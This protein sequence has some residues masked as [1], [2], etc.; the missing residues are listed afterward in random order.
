ML[1]PTNR[2]TYFSLFGVDPGTTV[3]V[4]QFEFKLAPEVAYRTSDDICADLALPN[5]DAEL[6]LLSPFPYGSASY[7]TNVFVAQDEEN[8]MNHFFRVTGRGN[9]WRGGLNWDTGLG[10]ISDNAVYHVKVDYRIHEHESVDPKYGMRVRLKVKRPSGDSWYDMAYCRG[11]LNSENVG[12]WMTCEKMFTAPVGTAQ[13]GDIQY[14][15]QFETG[16]YADYDVD[17]ISIKALSGPIKT[18]TVADSVE[19]KWGVGAEVLITSHTS[20]WDEEQVR[21]ITSI[22]ESDESGYVDLILNDTI[23]APTTMKDDENYATEIAILSR[24]IK[25]QGADDDNDPLHGGHLIILHTPG[26]GQSIVGLE[27]TNM[28]QA[29]NL[30]RYVS[31]G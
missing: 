1:D 9:Q 17:N 11:D 2:F 3:E 14:E 5:G 27:V 25:L 16:P 12:T 10:C 19:G 7:W 8:L 30:G 24:N 26:G 21:Q 20:D 29:G 6:D 18:V 28:G 13:E 31:F 4:Y 23:A 22:V 15:I